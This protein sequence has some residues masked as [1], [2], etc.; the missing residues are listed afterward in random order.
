MIPDGPREGE[1]KINQS[2][3]HD[4]KVGVSVEFLPFDLPANDA[5]GVKKHAIP[6]EP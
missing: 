3:E 1:Q 2:K 4:V 6:R 5:S